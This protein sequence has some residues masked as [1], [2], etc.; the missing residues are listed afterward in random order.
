MDPGGG[1]LLDYDALRSAESRSSRRSAEQ[2]YEIALPIAADH[3]RV[4]T[5]RRRA[6]PTVTGADHS[7]LVEYRR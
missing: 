2:N 1:R 7:V 6:S 3:V 4:S 5:R